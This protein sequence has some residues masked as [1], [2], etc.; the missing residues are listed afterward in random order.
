[1]KWNIGYV[2]VAWRGAWSRVPGSRICMIYALDVRTL[3]VA[4]AAVFICHVINQL[5]S[6]CTVGI[7]GNVCHFSTLF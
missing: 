3:N 7:E 4:V 2:A 1:M 5:V 6:S